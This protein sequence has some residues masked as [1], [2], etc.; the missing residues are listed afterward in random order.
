MAW[1]H[2]LHN[3]AMERRTGN[4]MSWQSLMLVTD[5]ER[6]NTF[7]F[8]ISPVVM[9]RMRTDANSSLAPQTMDDTRL[10]EG[11]FGNKAAGGAVA[12]GWDISVQASGGVQA[13]L[14]PGRRS[15]SDVEGGGARRR[16]TESIF[17]HTRPG[18]E[19]YAGAAG[20]DV[21]RNSW[22]GLGECDAG[23][24]EDG[25]ELHDELRWVWD[26]DEALYT[27]CVWASRKRGR[28]EGEQG[29]DSA[30]LQ[31]KD[32]VQENKDR[33][34]AEESSHAAGWRDGKPLARVEQGFKEGRIERMGNERTDERTNGVSR[35]TAEW[36][37]NGGP[38]RTKAKTETDRRMAAALSLALPSPPRCLERKDARTPGWHKQR[39]PQGR[40]NAGLR[41]RDRVIQC[42]K[43]P[44]M[45]SRVARLVTA[46]YECSYRAS[47]Y[48]RLDIRDVVAGRKLVGSSR[49]DHQP[50]G[51]ATIGFAAVQ[52][53]EGNTPWHLSLHH[54]LNPG[55]DRRCQIHDAESWPQ[56]Q[57]PFGMRY[58]APP[59]SMRV[60]P[61]HAVPQPSRGKAEAS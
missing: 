56:A 19:R 52:R 58:A 14:A 55:D 43:G 29:R 26:E 49:I 34:K 15:G 53:R 16:L 41:V 39:E 54:E 17:G 30:P 8:I 40:P 61:R 47:V 2:R 51:A 11:N 27:R 59:T 37:L 35:R 5:G 31:E 9:R 21:G 36:M 6:V 57:R 44:R 10:G 3:L 4:A 45:P 46:R 28:K 18:V 13:D 50:R 24:C 48:E 42:A 32:A 22:D 38:P 20:R 12:V 7:Y 23:G 25:D 33:N 60:T 1:Q